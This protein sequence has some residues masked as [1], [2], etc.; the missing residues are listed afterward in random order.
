M[1]NFGDCGI[2]GQG[3][4]ILIQTGDEIGGNGFGCFE[5]WIDFLIGVFGGGYGQNAC[6]HWFISIM[7]VILVRRLG[8]HCNFL[9]VDVLGVLRACLDRKIFPC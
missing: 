2:I 1:N 4:E 5:S 6:R 3:L 8:R 9:R 7:I